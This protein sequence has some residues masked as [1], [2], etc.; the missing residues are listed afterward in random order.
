MNNINLLDLGLLEMAQHICLVFIRILTTQINNNL[1]SWARKLESYSSKS[2]NKTNAE[3][4]NDSRK[5]QFLCSPIMIKYHKGLLYY[6]LTADIKL[7]T[8]KT[9]VV[10]E[11]SE[12]FER[13][14]IN[15]N[16]HV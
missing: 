6:N 7:V 9:T 1:N 16:P 10:L 3:Q 12:M 4:R 14:T 2:V 8:D 15:T 5:K 11:V 13:T